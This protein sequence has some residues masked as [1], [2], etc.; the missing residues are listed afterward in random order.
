M[1][2]DLIAILALA[3][4][5]YAAAHLPSPALAFGTCV[6]LLGAWLAI[7]QLAFSDGGLW[8]SV[9][10]PCLSVIANAGLVG[11]SRFASERQ[12]RRDVERQRSNL[13]R[14][15]SPLVADMLAQNA[16]QD[17]VEREQNAAILFVDL[18]G[19][20][21]RSERMTP[22]E[23][24][25][26][27]RDFHARVEQAALAE[28]GVLEQFTGDGAMVIFGLPAPSA[29]DAAAALSC[30][31]RLGADI[32]AW[33]RAVGANDGTPIRV[34]IGLH[35]GPVL[36][37]RVGGRKQ[38]HLTATGD[39]VNVASRLEALTRSFDA[40]IVASDALIAAVRAT[41]RIDLLSGFENLPPQTI[42]GRDE[43]IGIWIARVDLPSAQ[44]K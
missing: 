9:V 30:A 24:A 18:A 1:T 19:F 34:G 42:R 7:S 26:F 38:I 28:G 6:M 40:T 4:A 17:L 31:R 36:I 3:L 16:M 8:L 13:A 37:T 35:Y 32:T 11:G 29:G 20:T 22:S 21:R 43:K 14:Y 39:T 15:H 10:F 25:H 12:L 27:L 2:W 44:R 41:G 5:A 23:T 33:G